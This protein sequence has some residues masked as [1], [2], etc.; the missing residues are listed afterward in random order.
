MTQKEKG[1]DTLDRMLEDVDAMVCQYAGFIERLA[2][3]T[4]H[5]IAALRAAEGSA[6]TGGGTAAEAKK[7]VQSLVAQSPNLGATATSAAAPT[8]GDP[9]VVSIVQQ[10]AVSMQQMLSVLAQ[11]VTNEC[12]AQIYSVVDHPAAPTAPAVKGKK[13]GD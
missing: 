3:T 7:A 13:K 4:A 2:D 9:V 5:V 12:V 8:N 1:D 11:A 6:G 10:N